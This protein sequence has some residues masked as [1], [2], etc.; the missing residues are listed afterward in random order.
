MTLAELQA[1]LLVEIEENAPEADIDLTLDTIRRDH[2]AE[3]RLIL[4][5]IYVGI[6]DAHLNTMTQGDPTPCTRKPPSSSE[7]QPQ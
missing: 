4:R 6:R 1:T 5:D 7:L 3:Y 2:P